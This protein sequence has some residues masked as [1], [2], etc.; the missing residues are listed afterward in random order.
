MPLELFSIIKASQGRRPWIFILISYQARG[1]A[2]G[3]INIAPLGL[4][5]K[6]LLAPKGRIIKARGD[7]PGTF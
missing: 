5:L 7:A 1:D 2:P 3:Y 4:I 6:P